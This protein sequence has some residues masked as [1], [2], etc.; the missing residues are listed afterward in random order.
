MPEDFTSRFTGRARFYSTSRPS[1]PSRILD[2]LRTNVGF[3]QSHIVADIGSGTGLLSELFLANGNHVIGVEPNDDM[4]IF[5][6][7]SVGKFS[8]FLNV[9]GTAEHTSLES[10]SIDLVTVG[11][12]LHWFDCE[13]SSREFARIL[14]MKGHVCIV[15]ND[16]NNEDSFM[17]DYNQ[18]VSK[19]A[20]NRASVPN[21]DDDY[22]SRFFRRGKYS[23][24]SMPNEQLLDFE[25]LLGRM[26]SASY[27]PSP[28]DEEQ[29]A[30]LK[31]D[32]AR[33]FQ[34]YE[35][36]G[37]V[38]MLCDTTVFLGKIRS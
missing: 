12:A 6:E 16:R 5:A 35:Q 28:D 25:G 24:F 11:Q 17:K 22:L 8:K 20:R 1:Y 31:E 29:F 26:T 19:Y 10:A 14:K 36:L 4:R 27:M 7:K 18:V 23:K 15:Y 34:T 13:A 3:D 33:L 21:I 30:S 38:R 2:I 9:R 32:V 37:K